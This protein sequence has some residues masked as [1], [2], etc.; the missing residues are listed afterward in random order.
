MKSL[1]KAFKLGALLG[2]VSAGLLVAPGLN[3]GQSAA[4]TEQTMWMEVGGH[5]CDQCCSPNNILCCPG[6]KCHETE[7]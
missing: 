5:Y 3:Q 7:T 2:L 1:D 6:T 4:A